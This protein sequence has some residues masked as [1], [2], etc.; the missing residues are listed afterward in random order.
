MD[1]AWVLLKV[2]NKD[3]DPNIPL[4][5]ARLHVAARVSGSANRQQQHLWGPGTFH[6][7]RSS[8]PEEEEERK[9][10][11]A[12]PLGRGHFSVAPADISPGLTGQSTASHAV[13]GNIIARTM[14][15]PKWVWTNLLRLVGGSV[16]GL[17]LGGG[18][19][20]LVG[21]SPA[22]QEG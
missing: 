6:W 11:P 17:L 16:L 19:T 12:P 10:P 20:H 22:G 3:P 15:S 7:N 9:A 5:N 1:R 2:S 8:R 14:E 4:K 18:G 13:S 21:P